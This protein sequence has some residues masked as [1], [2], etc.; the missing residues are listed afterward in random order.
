MTTLASLLQRH[1]DAGVLPGAV[2]L[3][4]IGDRTEFAAVGRQSL[5]AAT[6]MT[7]ETIFRFASLT[8]AVTAAAALM[9]LDE[10]R[11]ALE[12]PISRWLP[13][14]AD[15]T[16]LRTPSGPLDDVVPAERPITVRDVLTSQC[17]YGWASDFSWPA[18]QALFPIQKDG[19]DP[20]AFA[21]PDRYLAALAELPLLHQPGDGWLYD[22]S[23]A[24]QGILITRVTGQ[25]LP[26]FL[27]MRICAP[28]GMVD[29]TFVVPAGQRHRFASYYRHDEDGGLILADAPDGQWS[30]MPAFPLGS[31]GLAGTIDDWLAF[32]RFLLAGGVARDGVRLL[33]ERSVGLMLT[34][35]TTPAVRRFG[36][37]FLGGQGWGMGG[38]VDIAAVE[39]WNVPGRYG[40]VGGTGTSGHIVPATGSI[41]V[42]LTQVGAD[43]PAPAGILR[44]FW[45]YAA[46]F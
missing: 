13:E 45:G 25:S 16:V 31:A 3:I 27:A 12:D 38:S 42:L 32:S 37:L 30:T 11:I 9:L 44:D 20:Q 24:L 7:R 15:P 26:D 28:L 21:A 17:G 8:K 40:W 29:T 23:S 39:P 43:S 34:D 35:H 14:L 22:V 19:R 46:K 33:A 1:V 18:V 6:P 36:D 10:G 2:A 4:T 41:A 5:D